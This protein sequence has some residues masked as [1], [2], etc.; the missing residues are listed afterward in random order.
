LGNGMGH[1]I[2]RHS[3]YEVRGAFGANPGKPLIELGAREPR[4][5]ARRHHEAS[6]SQGIHSDNAIER[7]REKIQVRPCEICIE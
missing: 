6:V 1:W 3:K 5:N 2:R 7:D 4:R